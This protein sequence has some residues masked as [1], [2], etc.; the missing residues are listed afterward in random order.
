MAPLALDDA[1]SALSHISPDC[2]HDERARL[3][4]ALY[5]EFGGQAEDVWK[6]WAAGRATPSMTEDRDTWKSARRVRKVTIATLISVAQQAGWQLPRDG[7]DAPA[8]DYAALAAARERREKER[9]RVEEEYRERADQ[10]A[11]DARATWN[12]AGD[13]REV[14]TPY[15]QRKRVA[16]HGTRALADGTLLVPMRDVDGTLCNLQRIAPRKPEGDAPEKRYMPGARKSGLCHLMGQAPTLGLPLLLAEGYATAATVFEAVACAWPVAVCFDAGNLREVARAWAE[17]RPGLAV[18]ICADDDRDTAARTGRNPGVKAAE[19][20][21]RLVRDLG[22][23]AAVVT[24]SELP[25]GGSDFNDWMVSAVAAGG[26]GL[27]AVGASICAAVEALMAPPAA[28]PAPAAVDQAAPASDEPPPWA[29][30]L[31]DQAN[32]AGQPLSPADEAQPGQA[33]TTPASG[34]HLQVV[35]DNTGAGRA[36]GKGRKRGAKAETPEEIEAAR[37]AEEAARRRN[38]RLFEATG[39]ISERY[40]LIYGTDSAWDAKLGVLIKITNLRLAWGNDAVKLWLARPSRRMVALADLVFEPGRE[41]GDHQVNM[42]RGLELEPQPCEAEEVRP[43]LDLLRHLCSQSADDPDDIDA[44]CDWV[45]RWMALPLQKVGTKMRSALIFHGPQGSGK[46][47]FFDAW[48]DLFG[49]YGKTIGQTEVEDKYNE[50]ISCKLAF[51]ANEVVSRAEMYHRKDALKMIVT[52]EQGFPIRGMHMATRWERNAANIVFLSNARVPLVLEDGDRRHLVV[53]VPLATDDSLYERVAA[54][55]EAGGLA[56]WLHYLQTYP[57][58]G[59]TKHARPPMT[60]DKQA[61]IQASWRAPAR[62]AWEWTEGYLDLPVQ[63]CTGE[64]LYRA[65]LRWCIR[66]GER[67]P[68]NRDTFTADVHRW[69]ADVAPKDPVT[70]KRAEPALVCK[71][72]HHQEPG[73]PRKCIRTW[74]PRK[75]GPDDGVPIGKWAHDSAKT[76]EAVLYV[77]CRGGELDSGSAGAA[78]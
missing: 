72:V 58:D 70:G 66:S 20:A 4:M 53:Y 59:F 60:R 41:V 62:F 8:P 15:L 43:M 39:R 13:R 45:L 19:S 47:L 27:A 12:D 11:R 65:F 34:S 14:L 74:I 5:A 61:L 54:W 52:E 30:I 40:T 57:V 55:L 33:E 17:A 75:C 32:E 6:D 26:N 78:A 42:F 67:F 29:E 64:Q 76:F 24:P 69:A 28:E 37:Q 49:S 9:K 25:E 44:I 56:K 73:S 46:N 1:R 3:A 71:P 22:G 38:E 51:V 48:R 50:W 21:A 68:P 2:G 31:T 10:A 77:Y 7:A 63:V 18:L 36:G 35:V 16:A 23:R